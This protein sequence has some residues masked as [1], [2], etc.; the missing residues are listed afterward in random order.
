MFVKGEIIYIL[1]LF[2]FETNRLAY[3]VRKV[4]HGKLFSC[5]DNNASRPDPDDGP[6]YY[7][8][9]VVK[10]GGVRWRCHGNIRNRSQRAHS[11]RHGG[12]R[13]TQETLADIQPESVR[14]LQL[15]APRYNILAE[16]VQ[17]IP[18]GKLWLL[19][20]YNAAQ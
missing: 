16:A 7:D 13:T 18:G 3:A 12:I 17:H 2:V 19:A 4:D 10:W 1:F 11:V 6:M 14:S 9:S 5:H 15:S 8:V 20:V